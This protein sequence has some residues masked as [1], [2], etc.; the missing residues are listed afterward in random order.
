MPPRA[1]GRVAGEVERAATLLLRLSAHPTGMSTWGAYHMRF[2]ERYGRGALVP[3][4]QVVDADSGTG[5]PDG[6]PGA[7][8]GLAPRPMAARDTALLGLAQSAALTGQHEVVLDDTML[9]ALA[10]GPDSPRVP[11]Q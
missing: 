1:A 5:W 8:T 11:G 3:L 10:I 9:A 7:G 2:Y 6:Y 4:P